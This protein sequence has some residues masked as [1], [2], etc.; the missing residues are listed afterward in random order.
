MKRYISLLCL[1]IGVLQLNGQIDNLKLKIL[2]RKHLLNLPSASGVEIIEGDIYVI[3]D[4]SPYLF[5]L[6]EDFNIVDRF[7]LSGNKKTVNNRVPKPIKSDFESIALYKDQ[8]GNA[9]L[10]VLSSGS[11]FKTRDTLHVFSLSEKR[12]IASKNIRPLFEA[13]R[14]KADFSTD[15]EI[16]IEA[17]AIGREKVFLMQRGNNNTNILVVINRG[18]FMNYIFKTNS[19][20]PEIDVRSFRLPSLENTTAG[21]SGACLLPDESRLIFVASLE[22]TSNSYDDGEILGSYVGAL[23]LDSNENNIETVLLGKGDNAV[24]TKL[25]GVA[26][27]SYE[28]NT[29]QIVAVSD[30]DDGTSVMFDIELEIER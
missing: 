15:D 22:A 21:F 5:K 10:S 28:N 6:D 8:N 1:L 17:F 16:N 27:K 14:K 7:L 29:F 13:I 2:N 23:K 12:I 4:D 3:G 30:N 25:E 19:P 9:F 11:K 20:L 18:G 24:K 26:V